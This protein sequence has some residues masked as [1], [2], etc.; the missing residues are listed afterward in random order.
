M[1]TP[2]EIVI[3][4]LTFKNP[5]RMA[6]TTW[7][8]PWWESD[9]KDVF[10]DIAK[11][12]PDDVVA[13][14]KWL[15]Y[16]KSDKVKRDPYLPGESFDEWG[17]KFHNLTYGVHGEVKDPIIK[18]AEEFKSVFKAPYDVL[19]TGLALQKA[20][21]KINK[22][23]DENPV[24]GL[25]DFVRLFER[26]QFLRGSE[27]TFIDIAEDPDLVKENLKLIHDYNLK[28]LE[29]WAK[30]NV[31]ALFFM[32]DWGSQI[33]LLINPEIW[34]ELFKPY[35]KEYK[36]LAASY[37]KFLFMH[38]DGFIESIMDDLVEIGVDAINSQVFCMDMEK[39]SQK[40]N[41]K[42]TWW[43]E[44]DRQTVMASE[45]YNLA[46]KSVKKYMDCF[47]RKEGGCFAQFEAGLGA[48]PK[49]PRFLYEQFE[50]EFKKRI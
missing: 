50:S 31:D 11:N 18:S 15:V 45:N 33:S 35:Y 17:C 46:E 6:R 28:Q 48:N 39:L 4:T 9:C 8:S 36:Q 32:D 23:Y 22:Y 13:L 24:F 27:E 1:K 7:W 21:D 42:I 3:D 5:D 44:I 43:G 30:T 38:S 29:F 40:Y 10:D 47:W 12:F 25:S 20:T 2:R 26:Y 19:P 37:G 16:T 14:D 34:R 41:G 49:M